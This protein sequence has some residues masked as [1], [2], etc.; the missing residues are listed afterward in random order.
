ML[1]YNNQWDDQ[2]INLP[3]TALGGTHMPVD[4]GALELTL[5]AYRTGPVQGARHA[6]ARTAAERRA[7]E[8]ARWVGAFAIVGVMACFVVGMMIYVIGATH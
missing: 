8:R 2:P 1:Y 3:N 7:A 5:S 4:P 6:R